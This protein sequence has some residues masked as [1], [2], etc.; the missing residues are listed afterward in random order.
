MGVM[1]IDETASE[2]A[3]MLHNRA[4][5]VMDRS[6]LWADAVTER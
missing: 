4:D 5:L 3:R 6:I 1:E 2:T